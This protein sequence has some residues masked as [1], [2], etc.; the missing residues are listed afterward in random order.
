MT[1]R[2][3][4]V[5]VDIEKTAKPDIT[6]YKSDDGLVHPTRKAAKIRNKRNKNFG[7]FGRD[8]P[9]EDMWDDFCSRNW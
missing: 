4:K 3:N 5:V 6:L 2:K 7:V 1:K 9:T 8:D